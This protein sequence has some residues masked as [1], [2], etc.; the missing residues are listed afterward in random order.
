MW[1]GLHEVYVAN[2]LSKISQDI[3]LEV[4]NPDRSKNNFDIK[5][6]INGTE[7]NIE[8]TTRTD[9]FPFDRGSLYRVGN[10]GPARSRATVP[11][12]FANDDRPS[13]LRIQHDSVPESEDLRR[14]LL[15]KAR[16]QLPKNGINI[17]ALGYRGVTNSDFH[18]TNALYG[19]PQLYINKRDLESSLAE[20][21]VENGLYYE[22]DFKHISAV[23]LIFPYSNDGILYPNPNPTK[24]LPSSV[25]ESLVKIFNLKLV[26]GS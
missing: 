22:E 14:K 15:A 25:Q 23:K 13:S 24:K 21:R 1:Q 9:Y 10:I 6:N 8:V 17:I 19:D 3:E 16:K 7:I 11:T 12:A 20:V 26:E 4:P 18:I 5:A 2:C